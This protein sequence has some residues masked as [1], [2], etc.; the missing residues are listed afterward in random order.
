MG[1]G[2]ARNAYRSISASKAAAAAS[3]FFALRSCCDGK[4]KFS[5]EVGDGWCCV[6]GVYWTMAWSAVRVIGLNSHRRV[7]GKTARL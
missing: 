3:P 1:F 7:R 6:M 2:K 4:K 5:F